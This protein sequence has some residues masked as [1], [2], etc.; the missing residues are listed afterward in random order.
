MF[1]EHVN[2]T[3]PDSSSEDRMLKASDVA[4]KLSPLRELN[5]TNFMFSVWAKATASTNITISGGT[6]SVTEEI[7]TS[8]K[9]ITTQL[10]KN[11]SEASADVIIS[12]P[13]VINNGYIYFYKAKLE[14][15][16]RSTDWTPAPEDIEG[17]VSTTESNIIQLSDSITSIVSSVSE[18][19]ETAESAVANIVVQYY[20]SDYTDSLHGGSWADTAP[21]WVN[22]KYMWSRTKIIDGKGGTSYKPSENGTCIAGAKGENGTD[23]ADG[24]SIGS[25]V[26]YYLATSASSGVTT[27]T[28][29]WTTGIQ[30]M[31]SNKKYLWNY[32]EVKSATNVILSTTVPCIIGHYA[33]DGK[34]ISSITEYYARTSTTTAPLDSS[35]STTIPTLTTTFKYLWNYEKIIYTDSTDYTS[36]KRIIGVYGDQGAT[37]AAGRGISAIKTQYYLS[38]SPTDQ[39]G[40]S[41]QDEEP[42]WE[43]DKYIWTRSEITWINPSETTYT[44]PI[45][46]TTYNTMYNKITYYDS[47]I[48]QFDDKI[49]LTVERVDTIGGRNLLLNS[50]ARTDEEKSDK[51]TYEIGSY[52][53]TKHLTVNKE[54]YVKVSVTVSSQKKS[55]GLY[56]TGT[57]SGSSDVL[58]GS[59]N[60]FSS[61][62]GEKIIGF[63]FTATSQMASHRGGEKDCGFC[64]VRVSNNTTGGSSPLS[65]TAHV[66]WIKI[67][68]GDTGTDWTAAPEETEDRISRAELKITDNAIISTVTESTEW[69]TLSTTVNETASGLTIVA[70]RTSGGTNLCYGSGGNYWDLNYWDKNETNASISSV[71]ND[72]IPTL[73]AV[74][75]II[76]HLPEGAIFLEPDTEYVYSARFKS[77]K[78]LI[79]SGNTPLHMHV[80]RTAEGG[81]T[82]VAGNVHGGYISVEERLD[83]TVVETWATISSNEW[84]IMEVVFKTIKRSDFPSG[85]VKL[86]FVP[87]WYG[88]N[89]GDDETT[90]FD[91]IKIEK[92]N[93]ATD[94]APA[95]GDIEDRFDST[96]TR[97]DSD[98]EQL[99]ALQTVVDLKRDGVYVYSGLFQEDGS[100]QPDYSGYYTKTTNSNFQIVDGSASESAPVSK[101]IPWVASANLQL[102][103]NYALIS[104]DEG[105]SFLPRSFIKET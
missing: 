86:L 93:V 14:S 61:G 104:D 38:T 84:H 80:R 54:Y 96:I 27:S 35:F 74:G 17:R 64:K 65:G 72:T 76:R 81:T 2:S 56:H 11:A 39:I 98:W 101:R 12:V 19:Q 32:E 68:I 36:G 15:G 78:D 53:F 4:F 57:N 10:L 24:V 67:E 100:V 91:Y 34:G 13:E 87:I 22:G 49:S 58:M 85:A 99:A 23:G 16:T 3:P 28:A 105:I 6:E 60:T 59:W 103:G 37:G 50:L 45:L 25:I 21:S 95:L 70:G 20:L 29:G 41:W 55:I 51:S 62:A 42:T 102:I 94:W 90:Y 8:W 79:A 7:G 75:S 46:A 48:S 73:A 92:G 40:G 33:N 30:S 83:R 26:N 66:N 63:K 89:V 71:I 69:G 43:E 31:D 5:G 82:D 52:D 47:E 9:R 97:D 44:T 77:T 88:G 1:F 18:A